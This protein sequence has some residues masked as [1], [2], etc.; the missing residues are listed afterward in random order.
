M[1]SFK[2]NGQTAKVLKPLGNRIAL[3]LL[4]K[5]KMELFEGISFYQIK[6]HQSKK[7]KKEN[8]EVAR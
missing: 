2:A 4:L 7:C 6:N 8:A 1:A 5:M 3:S